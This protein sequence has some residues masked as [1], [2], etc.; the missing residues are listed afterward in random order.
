MNNRNRAEGGGGTTANSG[1]SNRSHQV[2]PDY[3]AAFRQSKCFQVSQAL[4][5]TPSL[6]ITWIIGAAATEN[7]SSAKT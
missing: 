2:E 1:S 3:G 6:M 7:E 5:L 4:S